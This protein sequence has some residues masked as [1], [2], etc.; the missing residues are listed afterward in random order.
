LR[1]NPKFQPIHVW[2]RPFF[3]SLAHF[4]AQFDPND[5]RVLKRHGFGVIAVP[6]AIDEKGHRGGT[7]ERIRAG[8]TTGRLEVRTHCHVTELIF[9]EKDP[10]RVVGVRYLPGERLYRADRDP[11]RFGQPTGPAQEVRAKREVIISAGAYVTPQL[12]MLSGIGPREELERPEIKIPVRHHLPGVGKNLQDRYEVGV[13]TELAQNF[14]ILQRCTPQQPND[15]CFADFLQGRG[16]YT[17]NLSAL[18][19]IRKSDPAKLERDLV[20]F[21][22]AGDFHGY[23]PGWENET[24]GTPNQFTWLILKAHPANRSGT[25]TLSSADPRD[26]P[27]INFHYF[28]E[29]ND[30]AGDDLNAVVKGVQLAR[31]LN[32]QLGQIAI[33]ERLPGPS[34]QSAQDIANFVSNEAWG[35][36]AS[37]SNKMGPASDPMAVVDSN[38][39]V[40]GT[41]NLRIVDASVFP[42]IPGYYVMIPIMMIS[43]RASD[44]IIYDAKH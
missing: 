2:D 4:E 42:R 25:V 5:L 35:H 11:N 31:Q 34:V 38:F 43:E 16:I 36:H 28:A 30:T 3:L 9:D 8:K 15:P 27:V 29:G 22:A 6:M 10:L 26:P 13:V 39:K 41:K 32:S 18:A 14:T 24:C 44:F 21:C 20:V 12:L 33:G 7:R 23:Y 1:A 40:H 37:C 19:S 17:T